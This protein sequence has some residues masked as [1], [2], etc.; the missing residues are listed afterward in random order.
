MFQFCPRGQY[1]VQILLCPL[2]GEHEVW[3]RILA[4][5]IG[6]AGCVLKDKQ[7]V[8]PTCGSGFLPVNLLHAC[9][10][11][12]QHGREVSPCL[13]HFQFS[14][15]D[16]LC[17]P[18][19]H[20]GKHIKATGYIPTGGIV[21]DINHLVQHLGIR[22]IALWHQVNLHMACHLELRTDACL[23]FAHFIEIPPNL[24]QRLLVLQQATDRQTRLLNLIVD[25]E[26]GEVVWLTKQE[27]YRIEHLIIELTHLVIFA[28]FIGN[29]QGITQ[30]FGLVC[31]KGNRLQPHH[32]AE[33]T[34]QF[35]GTGIVPARTEERVAELHVLVVQKIG[36]VVFRGHDFFDFI[37]H[38]LAIF[39]VVGLRLLPRDECLGNGKVGAVPARHPLTHCMAQP[40]N[41]L[42][43][44]VLFYLPHHAVKVHVDEL[45]VEVGS[46]ERRE[47]GIVV[48][49]V[50]M[51]E[52]KTLSGH[53]GKAVTSQRILN[54]IQCFQLE[55][56]DDV[57]RCETPLFLQAATFPAQFVLTF[58]DLQDE[59]ALLWCQAN[60]LVVVGVA[61]EE[62]IV[63]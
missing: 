44:A 57:V 58:L 25:L 16:F 54:G 32:C 62:L 22:H 56:I 11:L 46:D 15:Q 37:K 12:C 3:Q 61:T 34:P 29:D 59:V 14:R 33:V 23:L 19:T 52:L 31:A 42:T 45:Q 51:E 41:G 60:V 20:C 40:F 13:L 36:I 50:D 8:H 43:Q 63:L 4:L 6:G 55:G 35:L 10:H 39:S 38:L 27:G 47:V 5:F 30:L 28:D 2:V 21:V 18:T 49:F 7:A 48:L 17:H 9:L 53:D 1:G 26:D 24:C